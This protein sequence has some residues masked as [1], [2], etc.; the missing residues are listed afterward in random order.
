MLLLIM[1]LLLMLLLAAQ[2]R[3]YGV[4]QPLLRCRCYIVV[5]SADQR[6]HQRAPQHLSLLL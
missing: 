5:A 2:R 4:L 1:L 3:T 6:A